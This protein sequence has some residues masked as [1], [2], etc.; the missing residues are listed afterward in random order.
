MIIQNVDPIGIHGW[1]R[2]QKE[3]GT[4]PSTFYSSSSTPF[5]FLRSMYARISSIT[6]LECGSFPNFKP[7]K[8]SSPDGDSTS[9]G[10]SS[11]VFTFFVTNK[12]G[13]SSAIFLTTMR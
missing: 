12:F 1:K 7:E 6:T 3:N 5:P 4:Y 9:K 8:I 11:S 13:Y 2:K 10:L